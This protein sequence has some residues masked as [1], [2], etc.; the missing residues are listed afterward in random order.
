MPWLLGGVKT[1]MEDQVTEK[2]E[3]GMKGRSAGN[4]SYIK[5]N[6]YTLV[7]A[8]V[9]G[10]FL[11]YLYEIT[12]YFFKKGHF[13][14]RQG[15]IYGPFNQIYGFGFMVLVLF[16]YKFRNNKN[17]III[18]ISMAI[19]TVFEYASSL[20]LEKVFRYTSWDYSRFPLNLNGRVN[21]INSVIW[22]L[23]GWLAIKYA[24]P[25]VCRITGK[26]PV[27]PY[28]VL[29]WAI[30]LFMTFNLL[31]SS[32]ALERLRER[33]KGLGPDGGFELFLDQHYPDERLR[34]IYNT[35]EFLD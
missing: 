30:F 14:N 20:L 33:E 22:G 34:K 13:V 17:H 19:G 1:I 31:L 15:V 2:T 24:Y 12:W 5:L 32:A 4:T 8:F 23:F 27:K 9:S 10:S 7:W 18:M 25:L 6:F 28:K 16:L 21:L 29:T 11:G 35:V 3:D 26:L